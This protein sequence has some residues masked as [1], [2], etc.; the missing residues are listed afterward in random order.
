MGS[1]P[2]SVLIIDAHA[3]IHRAFHALPPLSGPKGQPTGALYGIARILLKI[4]KRERF[5][6]AFGAFDRPEPTF[7]K[8]TFADYK[9][10]RPKAPDELVSQLVEARE[11]FR[12]FGVCVVEFPKAEADDIIGTLAARF[13]KQG[14]VVTILTGDLDALQLVRDPSVAV[15]T[16]KKGVSE[17]VI[18]D[19]AAVRNRYGFGPEHVPDLKGIM[20]DASDNIPGVLGVGETSALKLV[21]AYGDIESIFQAIENEGVETV[22][23]RADVQVRFVKIV[24]AH[25]EDARFSKKLA[26]IDTAVPVDVALEDGRF[27][28]T[29]EN[30]LAPYF[31]DL[32]FESLLGSVRL[33]EHV[34][35]RISESGGFPPD[36]VFVKNAEDARARLAALSMPG[37][38]IAYGWK[39]ILKILG[40]R[41]LNIRDP[42]FDLSVAGWII[43]PE[44]K[45]FSRETLFARFLAGR[46]ADDAVL[47]AVLNEKLSAYGLMRVAREI[48]MPLIP[49]LAEMEN[50]GILLRREALERLA[51]AMRND[52]VRIEE[53][54]Y[55]AAGGPFNINSPRQ[56]ANTLFEKLRIVGEKNKKTRTGQ[57]RTGKTVLEEL[58]DAHPIVPLIL[59]YRETFKIFSSFVEPLA[60]AI[61][62]DGRVHTSFLQT[63]TA[64]GRLASSNPNLQ[65]IPH[66]SK[67]APALR[68]AF[69]AP[70]GAALVSFD[71][72]Q[73]ELRLLA[74]A[75]DDMALR[76]AFDEGKDIHQLTA[77][78]VFKIPPSAVTPAMRR[79]AKTLN[80]GIVYGMGARAFAAASGFSITEARRFMEEYFRQFP[81]VREWQERVKE[82]AKTKGYVTNENGRRRWFPRVSRGRAGET[83]RAAINMPLQSLGADIIKTAM[84]KTA[85]L[86]KRERWEKTRMILSIH[87][88]LLFEAPRGML[89]VISVRIKACMESVAVL[90]V[91]LRVEV[92]VGSDWGNMQPLTRD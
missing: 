81:R 68:S 30:T 3:L 40:D 25:R 85:A 23:A 78:K 86:I 45:D 35:P 22:A 29:S 19:E 24:A 77:G 90:S 82:E 14:A 76:R 51:R 89:K 36:A 42:L 46:S 17:T 57:R 88:E 4:A 83:E 37:E 48:E 71:Y 87:D 70:R 20:G 33:P 66:E 7:R 52:L 12:A 49:V 60:A 79:T 10:H 92:N 8:D 59:E 64:T 15:E 74:H 54:V 26:T 53:A 43:D 1:P 27:A 31:A 80:F 13:S 65:N 47:Y 67:W 91:P 55:R 32:G 18:Y 9:A 2:A 39:E 38:K 72:S 84:R 6:H 21:R 5:T 75:A 63:G 11:L 50:T 34:T 69:A 61:A 44:Q 58:G 62:E 56:V 16:F 28:G 41:A 73:L